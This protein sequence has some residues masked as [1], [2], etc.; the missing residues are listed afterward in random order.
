MNP[1]DR[2]LALVLASSALAVGAAV[3]GSGDGWSLFPLLAFLALIPGLPYVRMLAEPRDAAAFWMAA[4]GLSLSLDAIVAMVLLYTETYTGFRTVVALA[5]VACVG[6]VIDRSR[7]TSGAPEP[8]QAEPATVT[9]E[10]E[11]LR[12]P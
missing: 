2:W 12:S 3:A 8:A 9:T 4:A 7:R 10:G 6:A 5:V 1:R 11:P